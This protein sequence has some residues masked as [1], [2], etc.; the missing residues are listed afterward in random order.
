M[1]RRRVI[2]GGAAFFT[3]GAH[4]P[5]YRISLVREGTQ[6]F[7]RPTLDSPE[8]AGRW[9]TSPAGS[10]DDSGREVFRIA[11]LDVRRRLIGM[12]TVSVG[13]L[14]ASLV[15]P[16]DVFGPALVAN[17]A[18][19]ILTHNHPSG[20]AEPSQ[21]DERIT[22]RLKSALELVDIRLLDH[23]VIGDGYATSMASRGML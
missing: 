19:V 14:T 20:V 10:V 18:G 12:V 22:K 17:A 1:S 16:R 3:E 23:L 2:D 5:S 15:P 21:A 8:A 7:E 11:L 9:L 4:T 6:P 13:T